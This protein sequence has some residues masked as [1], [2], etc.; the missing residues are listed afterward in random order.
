MLRSIY[1]LSGLMELDWP[2]ATYL[3]ED[4]RPE[5][6]DL[7]PITLRHVLSHTT[8]LPNWRPQDQ[9]LHVKSRPGITFGYS[10]EGYVYLQRVIEHITGQ[11]FERFHADRKFSIR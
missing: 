2:L 8:G 3:S 5:E 11:S 6:P 1:A 9:S 10:G 7:A 4:Q